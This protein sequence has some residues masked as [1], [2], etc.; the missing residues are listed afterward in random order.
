[1]LDQGDYEFLHQP[2]EETLAATQSD[3]VVYCD[4]PYI[5]RH[6]DYFNGWDEASERQL[7]TSLNQCEASF[8]LSTWHSNAHRSNPWLDTIWG[9]YNRVT[10]EHF[11]HVGGRTE[12]RRPITE[13]LV[14]NRV[15]KASE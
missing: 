2:F 1:V 14:S 10:R 15:L 9:E 7:A 11:Y 8:I 6:A 12:N 13:A 3:D 5:G 4:P